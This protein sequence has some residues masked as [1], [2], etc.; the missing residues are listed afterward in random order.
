MLKRFL[1]MIALLGTSALALAAGSSPQRFDFVFREKSGSARATGYIV[2]DGS[3]LLNPGMNDIGLPDG[4]VLDL[5]VTVSGATSGNGTFGLAD[6]CG[7]VFDTQ[8][9]TLDFSRE[10]VG[11]PTSGGPWAS[12]NVDVGDF[13]LFNCVMGR[14]GADRYSPIRGAVPADS[15]PDGVIYFT[16]GADSG[17]ANEMRLTSMVAA[18]S[19][20][21]QPV[22]AAGGWA[23]A[24][25]LLI[26]V[27]TGQWVLWRRRAA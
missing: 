24:A 23:L 9:A 2:F 14:N 8:G 13:N 20:V 27:G 4:R 3:L 10:L 7:V 12:E 11:Q 17:R 22:P 18:G 5:S 19:A 16:L 15:A 6:F 21:S 1:L 25:M 26:L